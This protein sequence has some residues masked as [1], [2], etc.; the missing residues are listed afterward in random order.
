MIT[1]MANDA[2]KPDGTKAKGS[3]IYLVRLVPVS[4][5]LYDT[6]QSSII[7]I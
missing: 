1:E 5:V 3:G 6:Q 4:T 7:Y 2:S